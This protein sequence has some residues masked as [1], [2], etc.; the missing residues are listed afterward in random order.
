MRFH[1]GVSMGLDDLLMLAIILFPV[2]TFV[3]FLVM[4]RFDR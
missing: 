2:V 3:A 1:F 4:R